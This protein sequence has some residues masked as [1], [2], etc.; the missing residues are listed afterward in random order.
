MG[1]KFEGIQGVT[2]EAIR[3]AFLWERAE[4][5]NV[6]CNLC[7][8]RCRIRDGGFGVCGVR[9]NDS[10]TLYTLVYGLAVSANVDPIE[11]KPIF[12]MYPGS[13]SMS[14]AT[15][16]CNLS[17]L[18]CQNWEISQISKGSSRMLLG[19]ELMPEEVVSLAIRYGCATISYT[20]T[21][22]TIFME[23]AYDTAKLA[24][25]KG[26]RN[27]FVTNGYM[28]KEALDLIA[29][30][31][32]GANVDLKSFKDETYRKV[33]GG[34]LEPVLSTIKGMKGKGIW[35]EVTTLIVPG[36]NDSEEEIRAIAEFIKGV[37][38]EIPWHIS[39]FYPHYRMQDRGQTPIHILKRARDIGKEAGLRYV[40][41][42]NVPGDEGEN[43]YCYSCGTTL[44][45]RFGFQILDMRIKDGKC[46][47]CEAKIDGIWG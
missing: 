39:R 13:R 47:R 11:K 10:G 33:M 20:Y 28:T 1:Y 8:R 18:F 36:M 37:G 26:I 32:D 43:T 42:G 25:E 38:E 2:K 46:P 14:I 35:V 5:S 12:H 44:I 34:S 7:P 17:C 9:A 19:R 40:Y 4:D 16:G 30:Y 21:E 3:E 29:P 41:T 6:I 22:P 24:R 27:I 45:R 23:Y 31:L 15:V